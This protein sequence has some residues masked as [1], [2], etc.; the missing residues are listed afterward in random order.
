MT[1]EKTE[2]QRI[3]EMF[4]QINNNM[5]T[6]TQ[7]MEIMMKD[8]EAT[9]QENVQLKKQLIQQEQKIKEIEQEIRRKNIVI[10]GLEDREDEMGE[11]INQKLK[12]IFIK[13][14][15]KIDDNIDIEEVRRIGKYKRGTNRPILM[16]MARSKKKFEILKQTKTLRG[17]DI[18]IEED[19][20]KEVQEERKLLIPHLKEAR[21]KGYNARLRYNKLIINKEVF[22]IQD[23]V[24]E[25]QV[26]TTTDKKRTLSE[27]SPEMAT[28][29][30]RQTKI[31]KIATSKN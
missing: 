31:T 12:K 15:V 22:T 9:K 18:W 25:E 24:Q 23:F 29:M 14:E 26:E 5:Q 19:Y 6:M 11:E 13:M 1:E 16:K 20:T 30:Q 17:T 27:R 4:R 2:M 7:R 28:S 3:E 8:V 21:Q 10:K